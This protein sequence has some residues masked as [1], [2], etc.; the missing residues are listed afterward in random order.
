MVCKGEGASWQVY[1]LKAAARDSIIY[2]TDDKEICHRRIYFKRTVTFKDGNG[3]G[4]LNKMG[5]KN[6]KYST[7]RTASLPTTIRPK[8]RLHVDDGP[9]GVT[10]VSQLHEKGLIILFSDQS[11]PVESKHL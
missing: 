9:T 4:K 11:T 2:Q 7:P 8:Q 1:N 10:T 6:V 5:T 3:A